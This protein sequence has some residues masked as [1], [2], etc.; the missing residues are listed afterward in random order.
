M[1]TR[2]AAAALLFAAPLFT[3]A[4]AGLPPSYSDKAPASSP[5]PTSADASAGPQGLEA[6]VTSTSQVGG[7]VPFE[8]TVRVRVPAVCWMAAGPTGA[9]YAADWGAGGRFYEANGGSGGY[10]YIRS[11]Y[12]DFMQY[13]DKDG[14]WYTTRCRAD[15]PPALVVEYQ[16][17]HPPRFVET[18]TPAP[19]PEPD[20]D[21][22]VLVE[23]AR[24][25]MLLPTG[26]IRWNPSLDGSGAT[27]VNLPT[28]VWVENST[29]T[30]QVRAEIPATGTWAQID[31]TLGG[32]D[33]SADG[34]E[35]TTCSDNGTPY[36]PGMTTSSCAIQFVRS[37]A[38]QPAK[39]GQSLPTTTL[40]A[41]ARWTAT[42]AS[43]LDPAP[44]PLD[45][46]ATTTT[47][48]VPVAEIQTIVTR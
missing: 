37:T 28:F 46:P 48:E 7:T 18:G 8:R 31:A 3:A 15:A 26:Q 20:V 33:L 39:P 38:N 36:A 24:D 6:T 43:S 10:A 41:T 14:H 29:T 27:V 30:V 19:P 4:T 44:R 21:P 9:E 34:A 45:I 35:P 47:A 1:L 11:V 32:L 42:W 22:R 12:P 16:R 25:A 2:R 5:P 17:T 23:A 40:T 13:A